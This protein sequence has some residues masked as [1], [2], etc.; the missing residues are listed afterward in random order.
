MATDAVS[1][2]QIVVVLTRCK[3]AT[4]LC[5][6]V[7]PEPGQLSRLSLTL[8]TCPFG[9][10]E[11]DRYILAMTHERPTRP[12]H[13]PAT[14]SFYCRGLVNPEFGAPMLGVCADEVCRVVLMNVDRAGHCLTVLQSD[15]L[16]C[17][18]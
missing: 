3:A 10:W 6:S 11:L 9:A 5:Y 2:L 8:A 17:N 14:L 13:S 16:P 4:G 12:V 15:L 7:R 18:P 1:G